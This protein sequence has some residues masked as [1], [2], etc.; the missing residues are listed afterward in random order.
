MVVGAAAVVPGVV[1][2]NGVMVIVAVDGARGIALV[3]PDERHRGTIDRDER[4]GEGAS[5]HAPVLVRFA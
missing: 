4:K 2:V 1:M 3:T 5:D